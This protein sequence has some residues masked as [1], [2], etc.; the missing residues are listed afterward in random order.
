M[1]SGEEQGRGVGVARGYAQPQ[2][3]V[4]V[5]VAGLVGHSSM[6]GPASVSRV[7]ASGLSDCTAEMNAG[8][9]SHAAPP[10][11]LAHVVLGAPVVPSLTT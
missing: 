2:K 8:G 11:S 10:H 6:R 5:I 7:P 1:R 4:I 9:S 3:H